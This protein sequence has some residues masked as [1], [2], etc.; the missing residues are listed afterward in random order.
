MSSAKHSHLVLI[1][2]LLSLLQANPAHSTWIEFGQRRDP[3]VL[4]QVGCAR[5]VG[6]TLHTTDTFL[7]TDRQVWIWFEGTGAPQPRQV[8]MEWIV[9][10]ER[11]PEAAAT[12]TLK[13]G[14]SGGIFVFSLTDE[15]HL[16]PG[17]YRVELFSDQKRIGVFHFKVRSVP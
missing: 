5:A 17:I 7:E 10:G 8:Q 14:S 2:W 13:P 4:L 16:I 9:N 3:L 15:S 1:V 6:G 12:L 11:R